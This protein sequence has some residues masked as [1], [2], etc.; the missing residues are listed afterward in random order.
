MIAQLPWEA[1]WTLNI[2]DVMENAYLQSADR[3]QLPVVRLW[4]EDQLPYGGQHEEVPLVHLH[5]YV[6]DIESRADPKLVFDLLDYIGAVRQADRGNWQTRFRGDYQ[7]RPMIILGATLSEELDFLDVVRRGSASASYGAPSVIVRPGISEF[8]EQEYRRWGLI[9]VSTTAEEFIRFLIESVR[10]A[11]PAPVP[12]VYETLYTE[13]VFLPLTLDTEA[14]PPPAGHDFYG[15][16]S[17]EWA[18][19]IEELDAV[20]NWLINFVTAEVSSPDEV[21]TIQRLFLFRG[22]PFCG[23]S[24]AL[25][26]LGREL[27][28]RGW[29]PIYVIG[30]ERLEWE[31]T[32]E[33]FRTRPRAVILIDGLAQDAGDVA[34]LLR[35]AKQADLRLLVF[36]A[37]RERHI[38]HIRNAVPF[39]YLVGTETTL[40]V[41]PT[42][43]L[44]LEIL[45]KRSDH[46][47]LGRLDGGLRSNGE[48][49][50][51]GTLAKTQ[52]GQQ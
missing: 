2:D 11:S 35:R 20:P 34:E 21:D 8:D 9:P 31:A 40:F 24:T 26:R 25:L 14:F 38:P 7:V 16:H 6:G 46:A 15:G 5:G 1:V 32:I 37:E 29:Q 47:R 19:V 49:R 45:G 28:E 3:Q 39:K 10:A 23:K 27:G 18:D 36:A 30:H 51:T 13:R 50:S 52:I 41:E 12:D 43:A 33:Y 22:P 4:D 48:A 44:W 42:N 17:P